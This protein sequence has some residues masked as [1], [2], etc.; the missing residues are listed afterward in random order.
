MHRT[1]EKIAEEISGDPVEPNDDSDI[2]F[3]E[4]VAPELPNPKPIQLL[5][6]SIV[7]DADICVPIE[8]AIPEYPLVRKPIEA[9]CNSEFFIDEEGRPFDITVECTDPVFVRA[10]ERAIAKMRWRIR[11]HAGRVCYYVN[12]KD[13]S[14]RYPISYRLE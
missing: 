12:H 13:A 7:F 1:D 14:M 5:N 10:T 3:R 4:Y 8:P 11:D 9:D 2:Q 6:P